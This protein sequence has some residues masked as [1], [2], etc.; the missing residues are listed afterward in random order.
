MITRKLAACLAA[1]CTAIVKPDALTPFSA[2][3]IAV[4]AQRAGLP[5]G[6]FN[7]VHAQH[8]TAAVGLEMC[9][10]PM[11]RKLSFTGSTRVG[12]I[13]MSQSASN[14]QKLSLELGGNAP[15]IVFDDADLDVAISS[16]IACKF[17]VSGQT[18]VS[19]NRIYVQS[20]IHDAF[21]RRLVD[22]VKAFKVGPSSDLANT[23]GPLINPAG[24]EKSN[25][26]VQD[27][28]SKGARVMVGYSKANALG[29]NVSLDNDGAHHI[30]CSADGNFFQPTVLVNANHTMLLAHEE[31]FGP[32]AAIFR[33]DGEDEVISHAND[34]DVGL[35]SYVMTRSHD[36][37]RAVSEALH[38]GMVAINTGVISD[39]A[40]P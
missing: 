35:A 10:N 1:G 37:A 4:L 22:A 27:A 40:A 12:K 19:A 3:A 30:K 20:G 34:V 16:L 7:I 24:V 18:C 26:H 5:P 17:K 13:L 28:I 31:T 21:V 33:F 23:H 32:V 15:F 2:S 14:I 36:R 8:N 6:T 29:R 9:K 38:V 25:R 39:P 11:I